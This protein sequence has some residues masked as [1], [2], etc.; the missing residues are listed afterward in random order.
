[1]AQGNTCNPRVMKMSSESQHYSMD[2]TPSVSVTTAF[3]LLNIK[4]NAE[5]L[6]EKLARWHM[7]LIKI[8]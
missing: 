6:C 1:M 2:L 4:C 5:A 8:T 3:Y 7:L